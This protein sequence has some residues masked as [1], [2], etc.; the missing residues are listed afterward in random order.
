MS[1]DE[2]WAMVIE[3]ER[4]LRRLCSRYA[5]GEEL[6]DL[7]CEVVLG[8]CLQI[9]RT[10]DPEKG[11]A[12][13]SHLYQCVRWYC[14]KWSEKRTKRR[15]DTRPLL[16]Y[17]AGVDVDE[18]SRLDA[19]IIMEALPRRHA[20]V[21]RW[22]LMQGCTFVEVARH[23]GTTA[24]KV[25]ALYDQAL[26]MA[27]RGRPGVLG[28]EEVPAVHVDNDA[29]QDGSQVPTRVAPGHRPTEVRGAPDGRGEEADVDE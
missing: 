12:P 24:G 9:M 1:D 19:S 14:F 13:Y 7:Y 21:L 4:S 15:R 18:D 17:D 25:S 5:E 23:L 28:P 20:D 16:G 3:R 26:E 11:A 29:Q 10:Y 22:V 27:R 8:K 6:D 2:V